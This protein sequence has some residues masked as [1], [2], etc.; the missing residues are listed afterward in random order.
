M[1]QKDKMDLQIKLSELKVELEDSQIKTKQQ[2]EK[3]GKL[4]A[5]I[6]EISDA[7]LYVKREQ[8]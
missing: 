1:L 3:I 4:E 2:K 5:F 8:I 7:A 6:R